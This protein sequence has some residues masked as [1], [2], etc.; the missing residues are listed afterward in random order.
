MVRMKA[1][2]NHAALALLEFG[3]GRRIPM[4]RQAELAECGLACIGMVAGHHG[5][6]LDMNALRARHQAGLTGMSLQQMI[7][8]ADSLGLSGRALHCTADQLS[9]L[10][11]PCILHWEMNHFVVLVAVTRSKVVIHDPAL[12]KRTLSREEFARQYTGVALEL[13]PSGSFEPRDERQ[14]MGLSQLWSRLSGLKS[15]LSNLLLLSL[16]LQLFALATPYY[17][18]WVVDEVLLSYDQPLLV[19]LALG[20]ALL[21]IV[22]ET[23]NAVRSW[24]IVRLS[25]MLN[26][27]MGVNLLHH[28]LRLP[29]AFFERR[30]MGDIASRFGSLGRIREQLTS[31]LVQTLVDGLMATLMIALMALYSLPLTAVVIAAILGFTVM[32]LISYRPL[33]QATESLIQAQAKEQSHFLE[34]LRAMQT[35]KLFTDEPQRQNQ[36]QNRYAEV[37]N[38]D[39]RIGR[40]KLTIEGAS[41]LIYTLSHVLVIYLAARS[42][43]SGGMTIGMVFAFQAYMIQVTNR[44]TRLVEQL[45][46]FRMLRLHL[47]RVS[48]IA[49]HPQETNRQGPLPLTRSAGTLELQNVHFRYHDQG[50]DLLSGVNLRVEAGDALAIAGPSGSGKTTLMKIMLGLLEPT[51]GRV[52]LDGQD[53]TQIGLVAYRRQLAAV[54]QDDKL[55]SGSVQDN[56]TF[57]DPQPDLD[58][59]RHCAQ[60]AGVEDEIQAK[61][62]GYQTLVGELGNQFSGGQ[63]QRLMLARALY[64]R[65][66]LLFMDEA[67]SHLDIAN[68]RRISARIQAMAMTRVLIAHRPDTLRQ[69][70]RLVHLQ[71]GRTVE[72]HAFFH[73]AKEAHNERNTPIYAEGVDPGRAC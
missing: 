54:M 39:I 19:V 10:K 5:L 72:D 13:T 32:R 63:N 38:A 58:W 2:V 17:L 6:K 44:M 47:E 28:L 27:Q 50:P 26:M 61:A 52:L 64:Q 22:N 20:F 46:Q 42:V 69:A 29:L 8:L 3:Q 16:L 49:L 40:L 36:W 66:R 73:T 24:A 12:G 59:M 35:I 9:Q 7:N 18:Q 14:A 1:I 70:N 51:K 68:E 56:L 62:M 37:I 11:R 55:L 23:T 65:P 45:I 21:A 57:F 15:A 60:L 48:D 31:G 25:S 34:S 41:N 30:Q 4:I 33:R 53:I 43:M 67:T 71:D